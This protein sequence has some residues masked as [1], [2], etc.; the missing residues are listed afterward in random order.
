MRKGVAM[1]IFETEHTI[2]ITCAKAVEPFVAEELVQLGFD[3]TAERPAAVETTGTFTDCMLLNLHLRTAHRVLLE[4]AQFRADSPD[5]LYREVSRLPWE[6]IIPADGYVSVV[7]S[8]RT[9]A[10]RD[11]RFAGLRTKDAIVDRILKHKD[12]RPDSG[13]DRSRAVVSLYW[14]DDS[15]TL[16]LDTTGEP[17]SMRGYRKLPHRAPMRETLAAAA[18]L[19]TQ[20]KPGAH[21][22]NPM[23]GSGTLAIE[24]ALLATNT[25]PGLLRD[26]FSFMHVSGYDAGEWSLMR[27]DALKRRTAPTGRL[28]ATDIDPKAVAAARKN[29]EAA[30]MARAIEFDVCDFRRTTVPPPTEG[31][32]I[33]L[34]PEYGERLGSERELE[35]IYTAIGDM[36]KQSCQGYTGAVFTG[37]MHLAKRIGLRT[38]RRIQLFNG[39]IECRLFVYDLY[40]GT[41]KVRS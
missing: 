14:H 7:A 37:N 25:A 19:G 41:R 29:A 38:R 5:A 16:Y 35:P 17:L 26:N 27:E 6:D 4:L 18:I 39:R 20:W 8:A 30:G 24:A 21:F 1:S 28:I 40:A 12:R 13:P 31:D 33:L 2:L 9:E 10:V 34:N 11:A 22:V 36:F 15:V 23:C 3:V 32:C